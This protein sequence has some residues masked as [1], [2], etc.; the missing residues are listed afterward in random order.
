MVNRSDR[1][2]SANWWWTVDRYLLAALLMLL[3]LGFLLSFAASPPV[4]SRIGID[5]NFHFVKRHAFFAICAAAMLIGVS[6]LTP[7]QVRR[8]AMI[9]FA[10]FFVLLIATLFVG[11]EVKGARRWIIIAGQSIQAS[12]FLK[13]AFIIVSA[14]LFSEQNR[15]PDIPGNF[16]AIMLVLLVGALLVAQPDFGQTMLVG[17]AWAA[18]FFVAGLTWIW[19][20]GLLG[21]GVGAIVAAYAIFPHVQ[22]RIKRWMD[23]EA[24]DNFQVERA[25]D[26]FLSGS[27]LG[28]GPGEGTVKEILPDSHTDTAFAVFGEE[29]GIVLSIL[30]VSIFAFIVLRGLSHASRQPDGF[31]RLATVGL[32]VLFGMQSLINLGV[33]L[34]LIPAKG[35]T[36]PFISYGGSSM[37]AIAFGMGCVLAL[38]RRRP[39][40][41]RFTA[42]TLSAYTMPVPSG[43][44]AR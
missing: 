23:P 13:P 8:V 43:A 22:S 35:M 1:S 37:V 33:N 19:I 2:F 11:Q 10:I 9:V 32:L 15:R 14:W 38:T 25:M 4:A 34:H 29:F 17:I 3:V 16:F 7:R 27:W 36:L 40:E 42:S 26:S 18:V 6:F 20:L 39:E 30:L 21:A 12:E 24:G 5:D 44:S 28:R 31:V 41:T